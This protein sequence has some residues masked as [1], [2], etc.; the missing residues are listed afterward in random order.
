MC[1]C[2]C[3]CCCTELDLQS[4]LQLEEAELQHIGELGGLRRLNLY[5]MKLSSTLLNTIGRYRAN[6]SGL[7]LILFLSERC[8]HSV[9][10]TVPA[11]C[12]VYQ[13]LLCVYCRKCTQ[14][15]HLNIGASVLKNTQQFTLDGETLPLNKALIECI[16]N[17]K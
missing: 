9:P 16:G 17:L 11:R 1:V 12:C 4:C 3:V 15:Q 14:L 13:H 2:V 10:R 8:R 7:R 5:S 6:V